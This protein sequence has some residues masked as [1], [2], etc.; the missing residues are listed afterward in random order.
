MR[1]TAKV[2]PFG[3][4]CARLAPVFP[5]PR[6]PPPYVKPFPMLYP[7]CWRFLTAASASGWVG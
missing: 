2:S 4:R 3:A 1:G 5:W 6:S 7:D